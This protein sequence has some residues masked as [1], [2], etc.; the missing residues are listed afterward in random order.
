METILLLGGY[1]LWRWLV[2]VP[3]RVL[4][5]LGLWV[6]IVSFIVHASKGSNILSS[7]QVP[8]FLAFC[9]GVFVWVPWIVGRLLPR[10]VTSWLYL[11]I[12]LR[13]SV[14]WEEARKVSFL[15]DGTRNG[16]HRPC[17]FLRDL[18][19]DIRLDA[20]KKTANH[21][22]DLWS[23]ARPFDSSRAAD[24]SPAASHG[25]AKR[26]P[27]SPNHESAPARGIDLPDSE[28]VHASLRVLDLYTK[29]QSFDEIKRAYRRKIS[30]YHPDKFVGAKAGVV[31]CAN[32]IAKSINT[33]YG[34]LERACQGR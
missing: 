9:A 12:S 27:A 3:A 24:H 32:E 30:E 23:M 34:H 33:A 19:E 20:L 25:H 6:F 17:W 31:L 18:H 13:V 29:P 21:I 8:L 1:S 4:L 16:E 22:A 15:F 14:S 11:R 26:K 28:E 7:F 10:W 5:Y 2:L